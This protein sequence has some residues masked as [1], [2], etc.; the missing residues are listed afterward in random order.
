MLILK[1]KICSAL[2]DKKF[3]YKRFGSKSSSRPLIY[4]GVVA[5]VPPACRTNFAHGE[6]ILLLTRTS[7]RVSRFAFMAAS[8]GVS[9][10]N[11]FMLLLLLLMLCWEKKG[12]Q[13]GTTVEKFRKKFCKD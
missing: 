12:M 2:L 5:H 9:F 7:R 13:A 8:L 6:C 3:I 1:N 11:Q 4:N 10:L